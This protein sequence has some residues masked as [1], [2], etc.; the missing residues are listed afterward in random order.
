MNNPAPSNSPNRRPLY[1]V[2]ALLVV[3]AGVAVWFFLIRAPAR[4]YVQFVN[5]FDFAVTATLTDDS[6]DK[7]TLQ[8]PAHG[9]VGADL[10]GKYRIQVATT[11]GAAVSDEKVDFGPRGKR[12]SERCLFFYNILGSAA[13]VK[14]DI[15]YGVGIKSKSKMTCG[16][17]Q[18]KLCPTWG[19]ETKE[20]PKAIKTKE[21]SVGRNH[22]WMHYM[23][24][25]SWH[26]SVQALLK[27]DTWPERAR[28]HAQRIM[29]GV[30]T[31]DP[32]NPKLPAIRELFAEHKLFVP[33]PQTEP[34]FQKGIQAKKKEN[35][36]RRARIKADIE[37]RK[38]ARA[39]GS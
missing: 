27:S 6:D 36:D 24:D 23:G 11:S 39:K 26:T 1:M 21:F 22:S 29:R 25:G 4:D 9:K 18:T 37:A 2:L 12:G 14:D 13:I 15:V 8:I 34:D 5:G 33:P 38:A 10:A 16:M 19:F 3:A 20:P 7:Q 17:I 31:H 28:A 35:A 30:V 32:K